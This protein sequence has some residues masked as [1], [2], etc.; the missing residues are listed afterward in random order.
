MAATTAKPKDPLNPTLEEAADIVRQLVADFDANARYYLSAS[1]HEAAAR[2]DFIDKF[3]IALG[4]DVD[5]VIQKNPYQQEV[6][7]EPSVPGA[8]AQR[9]ADYALALAP[10]FETPHLYVEAKKPSA[11][12]ATPDN[13]FQVIRYANHPGN[14]IGVLTSFFELHVID[15]RFQADID[16]ATQHAL[17][18]YHYTDFTDPE[19][20][21][22]I[23]YL[24]ARPEVAKGSIGAFVGTL[25]KPK[26]RR[27]QKTFLEVAY[28]PIDERLLETLDELRR[29]LAR[30]LKLRNPELD[31][32]ALTEVTQRILD[33]LVFIRFLEDK[34]IEQSPIIPKLGEKS[35]RTAWQDFLTE[36]RRL[37]G[38]YNGIV[39]RRHA[40][41]DKPDGLAIDEQVFLDILDG[42]DFHK[43]KYLFNAIPIHILGSMY[44]RFLGNVIVATEKRATLEPKPE[45]R[46]A[47]GVYYTPKYI[48]DYIVQNTVGK[49]IDGKTSDE[50]AKMRFADIACGSGS[51]L[52]GAYEH[53][54]R[55]VTSWY[56]EHPRRIPKGAT[57]EREG[58]LHL[59]LQEKSRILTDNIY[60]VDIDPQ[61]VEVAQLSLYLKLL[62]DETTA[63]ARQYTLDFHRPLLPSLADN[64][65]CGNSLIGPDYFA[66]TVSRDPK[67]I[68]EVNAFEWKQGFPDAMKAG[69][70]DCIIGNPPYIQLSMEAFR[71]DEIN[72]Y[73]RETY[74]FSGGR[75]NTF[76]FFI[77][78]AR[79]LVHEGGLFAFIVPNTAL[80][81][82]YYED[83]RR[84][85]VQDT[86]IS[87]VATPEGQIFRDAVVETVILVLTKHTR[88]KGQTP[89]RRVEFVTLHPNGLTDS[90]SFVAQSELAENYKASFITPSNPAVRNLGVKVKANRRTFGHWLNFNQAIALKHDRA[91][92]L[93]KH[94]DTALHREILDGRHIARY[95]TG[96]SPN[97]FRFDVTRI[98][99]CR[100]QDIFLLAEKILFRR[101]GDR[102][103]A[104]LDTQR[105][106]ALNTLVVVSPKPDCPY[107]LRYCLAFLN[108]RLLNFYYVTFL[109]SSKKVFSEIQARQV[110]QLP[111]ASVNIADPADKA[112]H[113]QIVGMVDALLSLHQHLA[114]AKSEAQRGAIQHQVDATDAEIDRMVYDLYGLTPEEIALVEGAKV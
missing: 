52:L 54:L 8:M 45:V 95:V 90:S 86:D 27:G 93:S 59:S 109:K 94:K 74:Q 105:K 22:K 50:I 18:K 99:S 9:H 87:A 91:A 68:E 103:I 6:K 88:E 64:I 31:S 110:E 29:S 66:G 44:E 39:F 46:K 36:S 104:S 80:S 38:I 60:G 92:C 62:E 5:H 82:E 47:G 96:N 69:G 48:V 84:R 81:Q 114:V 73:L 13:Y 42:F 56:R 30:N 76:A 79:R 23:F 28:K 65:K 33:R 21:A 106:F 24:I 111:F 55:Y 34:L 70:F 1:Y 2:K 112:R 61:A 16:T 101:V 17:Q 14:P 71:N 49:L 20:F 77:E 53:V 12:I 35:R 43:S 32:T 40:L 57:L 4:W 102:L 108:S 97:Y 11:D 25:P 100:R 19:K 26:G 41:L 67:E 89:K 51:F 98:H 78:R 10:H 72:R 113:D 37:D 85:L 58:V 15:C 75:L 63:S 83:L 107:N 7:V 3:L